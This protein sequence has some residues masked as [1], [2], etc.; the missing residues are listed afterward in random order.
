MAINGLDDHRTRVGSAR[1]ERTRLKLLGSA[2]NVL[3]RKGAA[4]SVIEDFIAAAGVSRGTF[5]NHFDTANELLIALATQMSNEVLE[6]VDPIVLKLA[7]PVE[8]FSTGTRMYMQVAARYPLGAS[9]L[10][11]V[12]PRVAARGQLIEKCLTRDLSDAM[13]QELIRVDSI[14]VARSLVLGSIFYGIETIVTESSPG[15][16]GANLMCS[17][18]RG[19][20]VKKEMAEEWAF[21]PIPEIESLMGPIFSRLLPQFNGERC[22]LG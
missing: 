13:D 22:W 18:L 10:T 7:D 8:R 6:A 9:F 11:H 4:S 3:H 19:L 15:Q 20:G 14:S 2:L 21:R 16:H 12:G 1:R 5:Y 17:I